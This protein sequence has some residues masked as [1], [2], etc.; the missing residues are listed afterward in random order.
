[1]SGRGSS[2][3]SGEKNTYPYGYT[4]TDTDTTKNTYTDTY[5]YVCMCVC[6]MGSFFLLDIFVPSFCKGPGLDSVFSRP[7]I[8]PD[9][10][11]SVT[12]Q[13]SIFF[14]TDVVLL[15]SLTVFD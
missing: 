6:M 8:S 10:H 14:S 12:I 4:D 1:V 13:K 5:A 11:H 3:S 15:D 9:S 7:T 2:F